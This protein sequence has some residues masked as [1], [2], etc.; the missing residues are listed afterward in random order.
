MTRGRTYLL[1]LILAGVAG[2]QISPAP[3]APAASESYADWLYAEGRFGDAAHEYRRLH[4]LAP[5]SPEEGVRFRN[6]L[7]LAEM[8]AGRFREAVDTLPLDAADFSGRYLRMYA[9]LR[10]GLTQS[11]LFDRSRIQAD[12]QTRRLHREEADL[13]AGTVLLEEGRFREATEH[14]RRIRRESENEDIRRVS[15][16]VLLS[17]GRFQE[18]EKK[19]PWLAGAL[20]ALLPGS[21]QFYAGHDAD[22]VS[23]FFFNAMFLGS[24]AVMYD[25]E[26]RSGSPHTASVLYGLIGLLFY[27]SNIT[28]AVNSATR[29]NTHQERLFQ[30]RVRNT[31]FNLERVEQVVDLRF[32]KR[33]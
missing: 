11:A 28:G 8:H 17:L 19:R 21:G 23:A 14:Y 31:F 32:Q 5:S 1:V 12:S 18:G 33:F 9:A 25:L 26:S 6:K 22:A 13:L 3:L 27:A 30:E 4:R 24:A 15:S 2:T 20:S 10:L 29:F 16:E 7:A